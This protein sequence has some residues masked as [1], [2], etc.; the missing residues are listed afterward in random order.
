VNILIFEH[1]NPL[2][3]S[4]RFIFESGVQNYPQVWSQKKYLTILKQFLTFLVIVDH[5]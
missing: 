1:F 4:G 5:F 3:A 2:S